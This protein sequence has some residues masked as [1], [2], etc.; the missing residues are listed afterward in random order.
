MLVVNQGEQSKEDELFDLAMD[1]DDQV[2]RMMTHLEQVQ[3]TLGK[4]VALMP[5]RD[6][7]AD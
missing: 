1:L 5:E 6:Y 3:S 4:L 2:C 7:D